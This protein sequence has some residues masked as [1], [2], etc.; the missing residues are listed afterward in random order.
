MPSMTRLDV[1]RWRLHCQRL[2]GMPAA[3]PLAVVRHLLAVQAENHSQAS[4]AVAT[5]CATPD[6]ALFA[7][8]YDD[9][10]LLRTHLLRPTW[11]FV[12]PDD[13]G[14]LLDISRPRLARSWERQLEQE[15]VDR[16][17]WDRAATVIGEALVGRYLTR[18]E[19][20]VHLAGEGLVFTGRGLMLV[21]GYT[22]LDGIICSGA[23]RDGQHTYA[24][25]AERVTRTRRLDAETARAE[26]VLRYLIGHGPATERDV[27]YWAT[28]TLR[29]VRAGL[30]DI[31][32]Q[33][34]SFELDGST[35]WHAYDAPHEGALVPR[36][37]LLQILDEYYRGYQFSRDLLDIAGLK[38][39][40]REMSSGMTIVDSQI[41][42]DMK[43]TLDPDR[44]TFE[45]RLLRDLTGDEE[46]AVH[47]AAAR[48][49]SY[50]D[51][52]PTVAFS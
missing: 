34:N 3:D 46:A 15:G 44:V 22:E 7:R 6:A 18:S 2:A 38:L 28:M 49:G 11:H 14:W 32:D 42:G 27:A 50:L 45:V 39:V 16:P 25:L 20:A 31:A 17:M 30:A 48:Y 47:D 1:A 37:Q 29:D 23:A 19:L 5:R 35:F 43:R 51:R 26:L 24:L 4:W 10:A 41:V 21:A 52:A 8:L 36:A 33:V 13:V 9:G 40:G 12:L